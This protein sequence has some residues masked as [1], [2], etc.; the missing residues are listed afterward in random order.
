MLTG[1]TFEFED[2]RHECG[3]PRIISIGFLKGRMVLVGYVPRGRSRHVFSMRKCNAR[4]IKRFSVFL[5]KA[6]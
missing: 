3:E 6:E 5:E 4:E 1:I 2:L